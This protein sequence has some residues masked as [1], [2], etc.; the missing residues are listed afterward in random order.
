MPVVQEDEL[1]NRGDYGECANSIPMSDMSRTN[2]RLTRMDKLPGAGDTE[3]VASM[4][5][6]ERNVRIESLEEFP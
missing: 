3:T 6:G 4:H 2:P 1:V 5:T